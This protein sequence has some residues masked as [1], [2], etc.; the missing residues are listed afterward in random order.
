MLIATAGIGAGLGSAFLCHHHS[1]RC[2]ASRVLAQ[3][4]KHLHDLLNGREGLLIAW[5]HLH[6]CTALLFTFILSNGSNGPVLHIIAYRN[7]GN[8]S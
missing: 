4:L 6:Q 8:V 1:E 3:T 5:L 7:F 2:D